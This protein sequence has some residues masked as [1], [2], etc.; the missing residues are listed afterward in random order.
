M[1]PTERQ[2]LAG[3]LPNPG[4]PVLSSDRMT[5][6]E[7][8]LM[9]EIT[10]EAPAS[11]PGPAGSGRV[12][13]RRLRRSMVALL[14]VPVTA[15]AVLATVL[16]VGG[17]GPARPATDSEAVALLDRIAT[18]TAAKN[19]PSVRDDQYVYTLIQGTDDLTDKGLDTFRRADWRAVDGRREGL[20]RTTVLSGPSGKGTTDMRL[21]ADPNAT[22]YRELQALPT[23]PGA[24][25][26]KVWSETE[27]QGPTHEEAALE[28]IGS[29][30]E[31]ATLLPDVGATLYRAA[32]RIPGITV[33]G[34]AEDASG[35][36]GVGLAFGDGEDRQVWVFE[37]KRLAYL[38][39]NDVALLDVG[40]VDRLGQTPA[41]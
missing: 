30:L 27:G 41:G 28:M 8:H 3:L 35:R 31:G 24:L 4:A 18:V 14:A 7:A 13:P 17:D 34:D 36:S 38:G 15:A 33:V 6:M 40:V 11:T 1:N 5:L 9:Q 39:S 22:T 37:D 20:A 19:A 26:D 32:A 25:Y 29:M 16:T 21:Q 23:D 2:E 12:P 10:E